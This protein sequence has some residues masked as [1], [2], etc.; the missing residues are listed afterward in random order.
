MKLSVII[1]V[2]NVSGTLDR[3]LKSVAGQTMRDM[4]I[5]LVD[6][7][8]TDDSADICRQWAN[9]DG[10]I[11]VVQHKVNQ[12]LSAARNSGIEKAKG[13]YITFVD[14]DDTIDTDTYSRLFAILNVHPDYDILEYPVFVKY[15]NIKEQQRVAFGLDKEYHDMKDYWLEARAFRHSYA[16][17]K[18]YRRELFKNIRYPVGR[19]F[20]DLYVLRQLLE[21]SC[22]VATTSVGM[23]YYHDNPDGI[24]RNATGKDY[25]DLLDGHLPML[26]KMCDDDYYSEVLNIAIM[27]YLTTGKHPDFPQLPYGKGLK[28]ILNKIIG[29][30]A[31]CQII[32]TIRKIDRRKN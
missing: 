1:P 24:T 31:L 12:G 23:Y 2:Y 22:I 14:S 15:G 20:E 18:I 16:W 30:K 9:D 17:N 27:V 3:C 11:Q 29:F 6:D 25:S 10:R 26:A 13:E 8:S 4:Q 32:K 21:R 7:A 5:I 28:A 19:T